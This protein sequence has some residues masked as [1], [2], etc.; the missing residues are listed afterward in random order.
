MTDFKDMH[1]RS[2]GKV[3]PDKPVLTAEEDAVLDR[4]AAK[5][6]EWKMTVPA[7]LFLESV[8]PLNYIGAQTMVFFEP[9]VQGIFSIG[10]YDTYRTALEKRESIELLLQKI[11]GRD[12]VAYRREK[13]YRKKV[14][15]ERGKWKWY[16]RYLGI[17]QPRIEIDPSELEPPEK[18]KS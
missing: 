13:L 10:D 9:I 6:V 11:E 16:Q 2:G 7:I 3:P 5:V 4:V 18:P 17:K 12:A 1:A 8:K 15:Q 14:K